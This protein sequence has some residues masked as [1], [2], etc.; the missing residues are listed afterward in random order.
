MKALRY[1]TFS[2]LV[3]LWGCTNEVPLDKQIG[4]YDRDGWKRT[5]IDDWLRETFTD[6]Y[7]IEVKYRWDASEFAQNRTFVP[8]EVEKIQPFMNFV[9]AAVIDVTADV[10]GPDFVKKHFPKQFMLA[11]SYFYNVDGTVYAGIAENARKVFLF[12]VNNFGGESPAEV[13]SKVRL[14]YH[15][16]THIM[17]QKVMYPDEFKT[18]TP[19]AYTSNWNA[20]TLQNARNAGFMNPYSM[21]TP[22]EDFAEITANILVNGRSGFEDI[23]A[24]ANADG[25][26][27][28]RQ[29]A[30]IVVNYFAQ[31]WD[32]D[33]WDWAD[34]LVEKMDD[35]IEAPVV[36]PDFDA[37]LYP[38]LG[39]SGAYKSVIVDMEHPSIPTYVK[40]LW[41]QAEAN[42]LIMSGGRSFHNK[43]AMRFTTNNTVQLIFY[44]Y[45]ASG[46]A[47]NPQRLNYQIIPQSDGSYK[48]TYFSSPTSEAN[49]RILPALDP[50]LREW[51]D[52]NPFLVQWASEAIAPPHA[53]E[54]YVHIVQ[55]DNPAHFVVGELGNID[56]TSN[57]WPFE[58]SN[59]QDQLYQE[60]GTGSGKLYSTIL[61]SEHAAQ[62][63]GF[64]DD[65]EAVKTAVRQSHA[66]YPNNHRTLFGMALY[67]GA[68]LNDAKLAV[69]YGHASNITSPNSVARYN[70]NL[71][72][73]GNGIVKVTNLT[74]D[75]FNGNA[76][77]LRTTLQPFFD[78][79]IIHTDGMRII[80]A[81]ESIAVPPAGQKYGLMVPV[82]SPSSYFFGLLN[83]F[84]ILTATTAANMPTVFN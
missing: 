1:F 56:L 20:V 53:D 54:K 77:I 14:I 34:A 57:V 49:L 41:A 74:N 73:D 76:A 52:A 26:A 50:F 72:I 71:S 47:S 21:S 81:P 64:K 13:K 37:P 67:I 79:Y 12:G 35:L 3:L 2:L 22:N 43:F 66:S 31:V 5:A 19:G 55:A 24:T 83:N 8:V 10:N 15:E 25:Q 48:F 29:K 17:H 38:Q 63:Q 61:F 80:Y 33:L 9:K 36:E 75:T 7:N 45:E 6:P 58:S 68:T 82:N 51:L 78:K 60:L 32:V 46:L 28:I 39:E 65:W 27:I 62:S 4:E 11:G 44:Y 23:I 18:I 16:L 30:T 59:I 84:N 40:N 70:L 69:F 42:L